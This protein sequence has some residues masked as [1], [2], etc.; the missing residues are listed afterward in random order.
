KFTN[1]ILGKIVGNNLTVIRGGYS[2]IWGRINGVNQVLVPLL[3]A[4]LIQAVACVDPTKA[5][6][7]AGN[8][9]VDPST[10][11]RIGVDG[12]NPY[13][14]APAATLSQPYYPG[15]GSNT[16]VGDTES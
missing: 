8:A 1:G 10:A 5:G 4:G 15:V 6:T 11:Y 16:A 13:L 3:G 12:L 9:G 2:R 14:P 7:C